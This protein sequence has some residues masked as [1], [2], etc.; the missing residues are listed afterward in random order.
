MSLN[1][2]GKY[3]LGILYSFCYSY[4]TYQG[5]AFHFLMYHFMLNIHFQVHSAMGRAFFSSVLLPAFILSMH[6]HG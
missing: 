5:S 2:A 4:W 6:V 1:Q 3:S